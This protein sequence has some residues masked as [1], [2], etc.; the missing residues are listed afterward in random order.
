M[1]APSG[2][3]TF[4]FTDVE[5]STRL[6]EQSP[7]AMRAALARHD[8][9]VRHAIEARGGH[10]FSTGG[11]GFAAAFARAGDALAGAADAQA[12]LARE[13]WPETA[14]LRARMGVHTGE[15]EERNGDY[16]G[17]ALNKAARLMA[18]GHG[19]QVLCSLATAEVLDNAGLI[20]LGEHRLRD[21]SA[22]Q[23][24]FQA[25]A[26]DFPALRS[27]DAF[28]SNLPAQPGAFVAREDELAEV[29]DAVSLSRVVT[30]TG[31]GGVGKTRLALHAAA[32]LLPRFKDGA[33][34]VELAPVV[35]PDALMEVIG[36]A[37]DVPERQGH[38]LTA[39][40]T[41]FLR[42]KRLLVV[43]DNCEHVIDA[44]ATF[45][46]GVVSA[47]PQVSFLATSRE[48][49][50]ARG[51]RIVIVPS[52]GLP[53]AGAD[54]DS[55]ASA[56]AVRLFV[57]RAAEAKGRFTLTATNA[58][59][60]ARLVRRLDGIP[61]ALELAAARVRSL[62]PGELA[63]RLDERFRLLA[64]GQRTAV[65]RHQ[66]LRR[67]ID[68]SYEL[69]SPSEQVTL[70]RA[71]VFAGDFGLDSAETVI[72]GDGI[73]AFDVADLL[74]HLVDKS[75]VLAE[76]REGVTRYRLLETIRQ[77]AQERLEAAGEGEVVRRRHA[78]EYAAFALRASSGLRGRDEVVWTERV[79]AELENLR[80]AV[81]WSAAEGDADR[82]LR[83]VAPLGLNG[84]RVA[85][86][87]GPWAA[88]A[89]SV[90]GA[91]EHPLYPQVLAF[92]GWAAHLAGDRDAAAS[93]CHDALA[94]ADRAGLSGT[95]LCRVLKCA[96]GVAG[97]DNRY[98]EVDGYTRRC[99]DAARAVDDNYELAQALTFS[100]VPALIR[101]DVDAAIALSDAG[102]V[103]AR[104]LGN[105]TTACY[106]ATTAAMA[107]MDSDPDRCIELLG[108]GLAAAET[109]GN[110]LGIGLAI[111]F[112]GVVRV[113]RGQWREAA[114]FVTRGIHEYYRA[115]DRT[116]VATNT[117]SAALILEAVGDEDS[118][119]MLFGTDALAH[120]PARGPWADR[121]DQCEARLSERMGN[122][123]FRSCTELG[124][125]MDFD[126]L[127]EFITRR[128]QDL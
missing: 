1:E 77:Y 89:A 11:D 28:P 56:D 36:R 43:L 6:W 70:N 38:S 93:I 105:P 41:D 128:L 76:D 44:V 25:G 116:G 15:A 73:D 114:P 112:Q 81:S 33:W 85:Y 59:A 42:P 63:D 96:A 115:G 47:C 51:E 13:Q 32:E 100:S 92:S 37:L 35:D 2:T 125:A 12:G 113:E 71:A 24:V 34:L 94:A 79:D 54:A 18:L 52:L 106:A 57:E 49:L 104:T 40:L 109:V 119:A 5:G 103:L 123:R 122:E 55:V 75:L 31:V 69:L 26:G 118:A 102:I 72:A 68:W 21:L 3:V 117:M 124:G 98:D 91:A 46:G 126:G 110:Q 95:S 48:G 86:A 10:V 66:T 50:R 45:V 107:W 84:T 14:P 99:I 78:E 23:R 111:G 64:G 120:R 121:L 19:G 58:P 61:L 83:I 80:V 62:T 9:I 67:A 7:E 30:L 88:V 97:F 22:P 90:P 16:F 82:A 60:V 108:E 101:G 29:L 4:L 17:P 74:G 27:L 53:A 39:S 65:E 20:D 87:A 127:V 8:E